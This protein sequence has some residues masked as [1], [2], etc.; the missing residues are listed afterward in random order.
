[1]ADG[2]HAEGWRV[3]GR[4]VAERR[5]ALARLLAAAPP[6]LVA[7]FVASATVAGLLPVALILA[8]GRLSERIATALAD[9]GADA[10]LGPVYRAF[11][12]TMALFLASEVLVPAQA[13]L[14]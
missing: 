9:G 1:M 13:R 10:D 11:A 12:L 7:T 5:L 14:R 2:P 4:R 8:G 3:R 6:R